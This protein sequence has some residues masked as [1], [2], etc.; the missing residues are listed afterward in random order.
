[1]SRYLKLGVVILPSLAFYFLINI[2]ARHSSLNMSVAALSSPQSRGTV[3]YVSP[4]GSDSN[5]GSERRPFRTIQRAADEVRPGDTV[6]AED[7]VYT[8]GG[9]AKSCS[10]ARAIVCLTRGGTAGNW[11][12]FK[13]RNRWGAKLDGQNNT[14]TDGFSFRVGADYIRIEGFDIFGMGNDGSAHGIDIYKGGHNV[15][16]VGNHIHDIGRLCT[17]TSNGNS[18]ILIKRNHVTVEGNLFHDIGRYAP[19]EN[20]CSPR[21]SSY[22]NHDHGVYVDGNSPDPGNTANSAVILNNVFYNVNRGWPIHIYPGALTNIAILNNTFATPNPYR[23][24]HI[25]IS[26]VYLSNSR[27]ENNI[28][29]QP[30]TSMIRFGSKVTI[31]NT[32]VSN[33][34]ISVGL[35]TN[36]LPPPGMA[37]TGNLAGVDPLFVNPAGFDFHLRPTSPAIDRGLTLR[38]VLRDFEARP[39]PQGPAYD[40]GAYEAPASRRPQ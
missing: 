39:R 16:I 28:S 20:G 24:G 14:A 12:V 25:V 33:N 5:P 32:V 1:M 18:G 17:D 31:N 22:T 29:F 30:T 7:G 36:A 27:I 26:G 35:V 21:T 34:L 10:L 19:G 37:V 15:Q 38:E 3:Y 9:S 11:V 4:A 2:P 13:S 6:I 8:F 40:I 23:E